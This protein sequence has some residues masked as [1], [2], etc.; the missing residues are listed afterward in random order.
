MFSFALKPE[1]Y[2]PTGSCNFSRVDNATLQVNL[3]LYNSLTNSTTYQ[4]YIGTN[5]SSFINIFAVN[6]NVLRIMS[7]MAGLQYNA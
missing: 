5:N 3:G 4:N 1:D 2:Q 6:Y 7:G